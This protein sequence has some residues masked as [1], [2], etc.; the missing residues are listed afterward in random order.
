MMALRSGFAALEWIVLREGAAA[1]AFGRAVPL[2]GRGARVVL[3]VAA[4][5][6]LDWVSFIH[7]L[8]GID[9]TPW[10]PADGLSFAVLLLGGFR[11]APA[12]FLVTLGSSLLISVVPV[13]VGALLL[14]T[15][16]ISAG[17]GTS[18]ELL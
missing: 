1:A 2:V 6:G 4:Y 7:P 3:F 15:T 14:G 13:P 16:I 12:V 9:I 8:H 5:V 17:Y 10:S 18:G 11:W